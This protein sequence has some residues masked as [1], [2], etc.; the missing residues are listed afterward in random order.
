MSSCPSHCELEDLIAGR[1]A[2]ERHRELDG[3]VAACPSC[4]ATLETL[5]EPQDAF[6]SAVHELATLAVHSADPPLQQAI[7]RIKSLPPV[8]APAPSPPAS[9]PFADHTL[10]DFRIARQVGRGGM[11]IVY[12]AEQISLG[13]KVAL[14]TLPFAGLLDPRRLQRFQNEAR[15]A[16]SLEHPHIVPVYAVGVD[17]S[18]YYY[19]MRFIDGPNLSEI[20]DQLRRRMRLTSGAAGNAASTAT[21]PPALKAAV[22]AQTAGGSAAAPE[23]RQNGSD[24][25]AKRADDGD[26][27]DSDSL[28]LWAEETSPIAAAPTED[29]L[30]LGPADRSELLGP[31]HIRRVVRHMIQAARALDY[32]HE[33]GVVHRDIKPSNLMLDSSGALWITDFGLARIEAD[34]TFSATGEVM[35]TLRYMSPEQA[36]GKRGVVDHRSDIYSLGVTLYELLTLTPIFPDEPDPVVLAKIAAED[37]TPPRQLNR[38]IPVDLET[39]VLKAMSKEAGERYATAEDF[40]ADLQLF[41]EQRKIKAQRRGLADRL[42]R[43]LRRHPAAFSVAGTAVIALLLMAVGFA[44]YSAVLRQTIKERDESNARLKVANVTTADALRQSKAAG[45]RADQALQEFRQQVYIQDVEQA[46]QAT[47]TQDVSLA[48]NLLARQVPR[49]GES[50]LRGFEWYWLRARLRGTGLTLHVSQEPVYDAEYS[51]DGLRLATGGADAVLRVFDTKTRQELLHVATGQIEI[52]AVAFSPD[53]KTIAT[54]GDDSTVHLWDAQ[55][56]RPRLRI[57]GPQGRHIFTVLFTPDGRQIVANAND[58][59]IR[60]WNAQT[61]QLEAELRNSN[62][63]ESVTQIAMTRDGNTLASGSDDGAARIWDLTTR[64]CRRVLRVQEGVCLT[65]AFSP[66]AK[67]LV[68]GY[69]DRTVRVWNCSDGTTALAGQLRDAF[70]D[71]CFLRTGEGILAADSGGTIRLWKVPH[72]FRPP[73]TTNLTA[74]SSIQSGDS[75]GSIARW[76]RHQGAIH[77]IAVARA[78]NRVASAGNDGTVS[79]SDSQS[80]VD[81]RLVN[82]DPLISQFRFGPKDELLMTDRATRGEGYTH[83][84]KAWSYDLDTGHLEVWDKIAA[85]ELISIALPPDG[86]HNL[87]LGHEFGRMTVN[88]P[89]GRGMMVFDFFKTLGGEPGNV[90]QLDFTPDM[91]ILVVRLGGN[92]GVFGFYGHGARYI[93]SS[94]R[95][96]G[97]T[98]VLSRSGHWLVG[99]GDRRGTVW[100][101]QSRPPVL[102]HRFA[103]PHQIL[104]LAVSPDDKLF[105]SGGDDR[106]IALRG[107]PTG[108]IQKELIGHAAFVTA[109][110]FSPDG[111][112]LLSGDL[113]GTI[114]VW[115]VQTGR[116]LFDLAHQPRKIERIEF[117]PSGRYLAYSAYHGPLVYFDLRKLKADE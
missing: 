113:A 117:S 90:E 64:T 77:R 26:D 23:P 98:S 52:N 35:G 70:H 57:E 72:E 112:T 116:F 115:S 93:A 44:S 104:A 106:T 37:P 69:S 74:F 100:N 92:P 5:A 43:W 82:L 105:A 84:G 42:A 62:G 59:M 67:L 22:G 29:G 103:Y 79:L 61:G 80:A 75:D 47:E 38:S 8:G 17:R 89:G 34:P 49:N 6:L 111:R 114:K 12:E 4:Q 21:L 24:R 99:S 33:R 83:G 40:A 71:V 60:I 9:I 45:E 107:L 30:P 1:L 14:K 86:T 11:G 55:D 63:N 65:V 81:S 94:G 19:A 20:I 109:L 53:G 91:R 32:A 41:L 68:A 88:A 7:D 46:A 48:S 108:A 31:P 110:A 10:G 25:C 18:V 16:A 95:E 97:E 39:I 27:T 51:P 87:F 56:G 13:R 85:H 15:A 96:I 54:T 101:L 50:D 58:P 2:A 36:L 73:P 78:G 28:H 102:A 76:R 3:H 66:D